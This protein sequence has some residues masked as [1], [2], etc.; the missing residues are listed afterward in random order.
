LMQS[1]I[2][3]LNKHPKEYVF[4]LYFAKALRSYIEHA[5][6]NKKTEQVNKLKQL[7]TLL[8]SYKK[9]NNVNN[10]D[11][12]FLLPWVKSKIEKQSFVEMYKRSL[13]EFGAK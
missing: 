10:A 4:E 7:K 9:S 12:V 13:K 11:F 5:A 8:D 2:R 3:F 6:D 1:F